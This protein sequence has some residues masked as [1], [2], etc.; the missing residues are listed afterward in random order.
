M[1]YTIVQINSIYYRLEVI[2]EMT[3]SRYNEHSIMQASL[4]SKILRGVF[5]VEGVFWFFRLRGV[6]FCKIPLPLSKRREKSEVRF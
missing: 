6:F 3:E 1:M 4:T 2:Q 5:S